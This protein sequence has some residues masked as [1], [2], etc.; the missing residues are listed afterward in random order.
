[1]S[2]DHGGNAWRCSPRTQIR[3]ELMPM[4]VRRNGRLVLAALQSPRPRLV[5]I[6]IESLLVVAAIGSAVQD[7]R[8]MASKTNM[9]IND[10]RT[11]GDAGPLIALMAGVSD[12]MIAIADALRAKPEL[13]EPRRGGDVRP[14]RGF[15][16]APYCSFEA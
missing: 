5:A 11:L 10:E 8:A 12:D 13:S 14:Y 9:K 7:G 1:M 15:G 3:A 16:E 6:G 2:Q 4:G